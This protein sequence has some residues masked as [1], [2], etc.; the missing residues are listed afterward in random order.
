MLINIKLCLNFST[1]DFF[2]VIVDIIVL[3]L[4]CIWL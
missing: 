4:I 3:S 2:Y 1:S